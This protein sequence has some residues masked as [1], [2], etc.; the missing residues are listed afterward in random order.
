MRH[1]A[2]ASVVEQAWKVVLSQA[3]KSRVRKARQDAKNGAVSDVRMGDGT[4][5]ATVRASGPERG[6]FQVV[7]PWLAD[8][9]QHGK[10]VAKWLAHRP[11][12]I[13]AHFASE[14][15]PE[16]LSFLNE[17]GLNVFPDETTFERLKWEAKC[18]CSDWQP[19]CSHMLS[20]LFYLLADAD[21]HPLHV[22]RFVG[23]DV[24]WLLDEAHRESARWVSE[25]GERNDS[26]GQRIPSR[27]VTIRVNE[28]LG[29]VEAVSPS[30]RLAPRFGK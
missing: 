17:N 12:W 16:L 22:F 8:Y 18:T 26:V 29:D 21:E 24:E 27:D 2:R 7:L 25:Q 1:K 9:T 3:D 14:W 5:T 20:L 13:A 11:D 15:D 23:L 10:H 30:G 28:L 19:L 6:T 4:I